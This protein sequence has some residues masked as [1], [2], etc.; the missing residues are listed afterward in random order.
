[1]FNQTINKPPVNIENEPKT[2]L[3]IAGNTAH[4]QKV[5]QGIRKYVIRYRVRLHIFMIALYSY[6]SVAKAVKAMKGFMQMKKDVWGFKGNL[7]MVEVDGKFYFSLYAPGFPSSIFNNYIRGELN[8]VVPIK[9]KTN[10]LSFIFFAIT[11]KCPLQCE[12]CFEWDNLNQKETFT[13]EE[14]EQVVKKFQRDGIS[15]FHLS[16]GEP[17]VRVKDLEALIAHADKKSEFWILTSGFHLTAESAK[18]LKKAGATGVVISLDHVD[19]EAHNAFRGFDQA[20]QWVLKAVQN[21]KAQKLVV[22]LTVCATRSFTTWDNLMAYVNLA[23]SLGVSFVQVLEPKPVGHYQ[24]KQVQLSPEQLKML[25]D[26]YTTLNYDPQYKDYPIILYHGFHQRRIGCFS[27]GNRNLY[28]DAAG[29]VNSCPFCQSKT[30]NIKD[31]IGEE[32]Q[33]QLQSSMHCPLY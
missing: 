3:S 5:L 13:L 22:A 17:L 15:Q 7:K 31:A 29:Y 9:K 1:M 25:E 6:A 30:Y 16:G 20:Y 23:R 18:R 24:G 2:F 32:K 8:R 19:A 14:L 4:Q 21:A 27:A 26:F 12:H 11:R 10:P 28:I 33:Q